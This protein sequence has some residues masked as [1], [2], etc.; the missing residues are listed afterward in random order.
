MKHRRPTL[1]HAF[2]VLSVVVAALLAVYGFGIFT[3]YRDALDT[4]FHSASQQRAW[5]ILDRVQRFYDQ[6]AAAFKRHEDDHYRILAQVQRYFRRHGPHAPLEPLQQLLKAD[7]GTYH[8][9]I[10]DRND[11][12]V[13]T[14][15]APDLGLNLSM[16][17]GVSAL[18]ARLRRHPDLIDLSDIFFDVTAQT[19]KRY[20]AQ[21]MA[22]APYIINIGLQL[23]TSSTTG[24]YLGKLRT[25]EPTLKTIGLYRVYDQQAASYPVQ[26]ERIWALHSRHDKRSYFS[27]S[28]ADRSA[29]LLELFKRLGTP[30][31]NDRRLFG[32]IQALFS[33]H[34]ILERFFSENGCYCHE[35]VLPLRAYLNLRTASTD[36]LVLTFD[37]TDAHRH[38][39]SVRTLL[40]ASLSLFVLLLGGI[41]YWLY[42][43]I[44]VPMVTLEHSMRRNIPAD[45]KTLEN[46]FEEI[47]QTASAYNAL[48]DALHAEIKKNKTLLERFRTFAS[49]II[50]QVRTPLSVMKI[51]SEAASGDQD[52]S[53]LLRSSIVSI[54][55]MLDT[56]AHSFQRNSIVFER[57]SLDLSALLEKRIET[58]RIVAEANDM[59]IEARIRHGIV[60]DANATEMEL[61]VD[62]NLSNA[63]KH[64]NPGSL[65]VV[66]LK[67]LELE[68]V[69]IFENEGEPIEDVSGVFRRYTRENRTS[70][71][72]G[73]GLATVADIC[74]RYHCLVD[75][76]H[77]RGRNRFIYFLPTASDVTPM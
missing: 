42:R 5:R 40:V 54:E 30:F 21:K 72:S 39:R 52:A 64:G 49:D 65:V 60:I 8:L 34:D 20:I 41:F 58:F 44:I 22:K 76:R 68:T 28:N 11:T 1:R 13:R 32:H 55:H 37:E 33:D 31:A 62:N 4:A 25:V 71:G 56:L 59:Q 73:I 7:Y 9:H 36:L 67:H 18:Y 38:L 15:Y 53:T 74:L 77:E 69:L 24:S 46:S 19:Q 47:A 14:T 35:V 66:T 45:E 70:Q 23:N 16:F 75:V 6:T 10:V 27:N 26:T 61:L 3:A 2:F 48:H 17:P 63:I 57:H 50:H 51:T 43:K 29:E 12:I